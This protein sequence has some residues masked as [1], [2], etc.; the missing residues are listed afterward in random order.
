MIDRDNNT[1]VYVKFS[2]TAYEYM[3][4]YSKFVGSSVSDFVRQAVAERIIKLGDI[5]FKE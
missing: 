1:S 4:Q 2:N 5:K 3:K